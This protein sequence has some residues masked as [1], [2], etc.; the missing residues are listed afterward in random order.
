MF[1]A[2]EWRFE[3]MSVCVSVYDGDI[4]RQRGRKPECALRKI[5]SG[6]SSACRDEA[7]IFYLT[8]VSSKGERRQKIKKATASKQAG[9]SKGSPL[10]MIARFLY[11]GF[12]APVQLCNH[13][14]PFKRALQSIRREFQPKSCA[15]VC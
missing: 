8:E 13:V 7:C 1:V 12:V 15:T 6:V 3:R 9:V 14:P 11:M 5:P 4:E 2:L 10:H